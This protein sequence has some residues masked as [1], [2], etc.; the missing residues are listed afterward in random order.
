MDTSENDIP[1][2]DETKDQ[3]TEK[4]E[5]DKTSNGQTTT[6]DVPPIETKVVAEEKTEDTTKTN[7]PA[8]SS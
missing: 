8:D 3:K 1:T 2:G 7:P 5:E 4:P 6:Q